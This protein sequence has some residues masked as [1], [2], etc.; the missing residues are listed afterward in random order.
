MRYM[1]FTV[2]IL[3]SLSRERYYVGH[4][5]DTVKRMSEHNSG[6]VKS[7]KAFVPWKIVYTEN[8]E[9]KSEA[10]KREM[11]IKRYKSGDA[12]KKLISSARRDG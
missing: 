11:Q 8:F 12:F 10:F 9:S 4:S 2:Y 5:A 1:S 6:K 7:T 3:K